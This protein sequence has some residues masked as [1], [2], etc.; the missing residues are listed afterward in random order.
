VISLFSDVFY[1]IF[2]NSNHF[3]ILFC[4]ADV[5]FN[6]GGEEEIYC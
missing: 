5:A 1:F 2:F 6:W 3:P 4:S